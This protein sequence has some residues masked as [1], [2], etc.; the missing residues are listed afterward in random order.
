MEDT[1]GRGRSKSCFCSQPLEPIRF[2]VTQGDA[3]PP[4]PWT[5]FAQ[6]L[7]MYLTMFEWP[8]INKSSIK[9]LGIF[10]SMLHKKVQQTKEVQCQS[11]W[12][13]SPLSEVDHL[14][15]QER[16]VKILSA[17]ISGGIVV[18]KKHALLKE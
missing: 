14:H 15:H 2:K 1:G 16:T 4:T 8:E 12:I 18:R 7:K 11:M 10:A 3:V 5:D 13:F 17:S 6:E 9:N